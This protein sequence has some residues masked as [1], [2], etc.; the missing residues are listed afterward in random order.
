MQCA[1]KQKKNEPNNMKM[2]KIRSWDNFTVQHCMPNAK[3]PLQIA[4][5]KGKQASA[6]SEPKQ[7]PHRGEAEQIK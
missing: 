5:R 7:W 2:D 3:Q 1:H 6:R 4:T